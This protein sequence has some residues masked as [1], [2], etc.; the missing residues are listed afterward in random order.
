MARRAGAVGVLVTTGVHG[1]IP[2]QDIPDDQMP[3]L[4]IDGL[5]E[6]GAA[7]RPD[8]AL[9]RRRCGNGP[10]SGRELT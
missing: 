7:A 6:L 1:A 4:I 8:R 10:R 3:D 9:G 5:S 2:V